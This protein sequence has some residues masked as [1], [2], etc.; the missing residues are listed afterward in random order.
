MRLPERLDNFLD[1]PYKTMVAVT[2]AGSLIFLASAVTAPEM[3]AYSVP[4]GLAYTIGSMVAAR[5]MKK[6]LL[7]Q[8]VVEEAPNVLPFPLEKSA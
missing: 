3:R 7:I 4:V 1:D 5:H 6:N 2:A 8:Q